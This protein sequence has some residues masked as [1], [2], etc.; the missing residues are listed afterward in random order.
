MNGKLNFLQDTCVKKWY[1][2]CVYYVENRIYLP[3]S[4]NKHVGK[5]YRFRQQ[6]FDRGSPLVICFS[7]V[8]LVP[9]YFNEYKNVHS[10]CCFSAVRPSIHALSIFWLLT[11]S[12]GGH[13]FSIAPIQFWFSSKVFNSDVATDS[14]FIVPLQIN[15]NWLSASSYV[16]S[17]WAILYSYLSLSVNQLFQNFPYPVAIAGQNRRRPTCPFER[18]N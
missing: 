5:A 6:Y 10:N 14:F 7:Y 9:Q 1:T 13:F 12:L 16:L 15:Q 17:V 18:P 3:W 8:L 4:G 11:G 2:F